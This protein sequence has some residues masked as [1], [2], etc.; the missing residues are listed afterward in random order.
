MGLQ[1]RLKPWL[2]SQTFCCVSAH[3][4]MFTVKK[5]SRLLAKDDR[6]VFIVH[7][8]LVNEVL[9]PIVHL[10]EEKILQKRSFTL[11][12]GS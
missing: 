2:F 4:E 7:K 12:D 8:Y 11:A 10:I 9:E 3:K 6:E 1:R 5:K